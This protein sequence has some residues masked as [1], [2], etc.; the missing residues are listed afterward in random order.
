VR[1]RARVGLGDE[2]RRQGHRPP[3]PLEARYGV[4]RPH[5]PG[6]PPRDRRHR[7]PRGEV[8]HLPAAAADVVA[9]EGARGL[10]SGPSA[11]R[12][13]LSRGR[14]D[15][16]RARAGADRGLD[17]GR[18]V[19]TFAALL[20]LALAAPAPAPAAEAERVV[21]ISAKRFEFTPSTIELKVGEPVILELSALD[22]KHGFAAPDLHIVEVI[23][24]GKVTR[25]RIVP[26][27]P[28]TFTFRCSVFCRSG[29]EDMTREILLVP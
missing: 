13:R 18:K 1:P 7:A 29:H 10:G 2:G 11:A 24:P 9:E 4:L 28:G 22:R 15:G 20:F 27:R 19:K 3:R 17:G 21:S 5:P 26:D 8:A 16:R 23:L 14:R 6:A 12:P 25:I